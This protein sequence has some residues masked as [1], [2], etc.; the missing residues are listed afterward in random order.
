MC[1]H[2]RRRRPA[3]H[4]ASRRPD[5]PL[6]TCPD[7]QLERI[8][9]LPE[10]CISTA[11]GLQSLRSASENSVRIANTSCGFQKPAAQ[12]QLEQVSGSSGRSQHCSAGLKTLAEAR[13]QRAEAGEGG[14]HDGRRLLRA[15]VCLE[16]LGH[17]VMLSGARFGPSLDN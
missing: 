13:L 14:G 16:Q 2:L 9:S 15:M 3:S 5:A 7:L 12:E 4:P 8:P 6:R 17:V 10:G 11:D 1:C